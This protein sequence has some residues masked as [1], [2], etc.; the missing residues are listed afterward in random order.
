MRNVNKPKEAKKLSNFYEFLDI[1]TP[2]NWA[3]TG[4]GGETTTI[5]LKYKFKDPN[6]DIISLWD[7]PGGGTD[8]FPANM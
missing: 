6:M 5:V 2:H 3:M 8:N 7:L 1:F 4:S